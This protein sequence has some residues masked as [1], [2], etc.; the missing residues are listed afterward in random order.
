M[1]ACRDSR[2]RSAR[3]HPGSS[4]TSGRIWS[5]RR[6]SRCSAS[7]PLISRSIE[8]LVDPADRFD[9]ERRFAKIGQYEELA[10]AVA[11][12]GRLSDRA[13]SAP[14]IV[15]ITK[16]GPRVRPLAGPKRGASIGLEDPGIAG[17]MPAGVLATSVAG[18]KEHHCWPVAIP[19]QPLDQIAAA[20]AK[21]KTRDRRTD[22]ARAPSGPAPPGC[23]TP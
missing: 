19:P 3:I 17:E 20:V 16:P 12:A 8:D 5:W 11:P 23:R 2:A 4:L 9:S 15:E 14:G 7:V 10:P 21:A 6:A 18:I 1:S 22:P 13:G